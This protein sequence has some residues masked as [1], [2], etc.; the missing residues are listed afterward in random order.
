MATFYHQMII[1]MI[2]LLSSSHPEKLNSK[3]FK[4]QNLWADIINKLIPFQLSDDDRR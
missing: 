2:I 1:Q 4:K 3:Q